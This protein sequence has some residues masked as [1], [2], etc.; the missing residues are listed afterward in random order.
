MLCAC[1]RLVGWSGR[2]ETNETNETKKSASKKAS[3]QH[4]ADGCGLVFVGVQRQSAASSQHRNIDSE[5]HSN[6][7][8]MTEKLFILRVLCTS[9]LVLAGRSFPGVAAAASQSVA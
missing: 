2:N 3:G 8:C 6:F 4:V 7:M 1:G 5:S 9:G